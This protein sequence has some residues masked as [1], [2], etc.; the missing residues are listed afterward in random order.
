MVMLVVLLIIIIIKKMIFVIPYI[1]TCMCVFQS[2]ERVVVQNILHGQPPPLCEA[3]QS[4]SRWKVI[5]VR[6]RRWFIH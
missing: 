4:V 2:F 1:A 5:Q 6:P 3:I